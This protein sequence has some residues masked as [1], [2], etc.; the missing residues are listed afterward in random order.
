MKFHESGLPKNKI[1]ANNAR[2]I[3]ARRMVGPSPACESL[4]VKCHSIGRLASHER[5][6]C[7]HPIYF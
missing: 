3:V 2:K 5:L 7:L 4:A 1:V 6:S